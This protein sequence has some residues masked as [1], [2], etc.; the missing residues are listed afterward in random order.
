[1]CSA[2]AGDYEDPEATA[3]AEGED[4]DC[5]GEEQACVTSFPGS[6]KRHG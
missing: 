6:A 2:C 1:M 5:D 3:W 4:E